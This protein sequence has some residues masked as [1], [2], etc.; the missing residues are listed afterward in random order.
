MLRAWIHLSEQVAGQIL[1]YFLI[2]LFILGLSELLDKCLYSASQNEPATTEV[3]LDS[4][5]SKEIPT[6]DPE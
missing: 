1:R 5:E 2:G 6:A 3:V 4:E